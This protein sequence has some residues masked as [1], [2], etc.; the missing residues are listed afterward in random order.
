MAEPDQACH[1]P[2]LQDYCHRVILANIE[3]QQS[4]TAGSA[5]S[6]TCLGLAVR[7]TGDMPFRVIRPVLEKCKVHKL[8]HLEQESP[9]GSMLHLHRV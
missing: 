1:V 7:S 8:L 3:C 2:R 9:V 6:N 4:I 5:Y